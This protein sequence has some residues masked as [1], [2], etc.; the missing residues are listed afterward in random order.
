MAVK[1]SST[2]FKTLLNQF[3]PSVDVKMLKCLPNEEASAI[4][5]DPTT[6]Q[7][8]LS[9]LSWPQQLIGRVHYSWLTPV[10][11]NVSSI[12]R[13]SAIAALPEHQS[14]KLKTH[15]KISGPLP[16]L[17]NPIKQ[18]WAGLLFRQWAPE[19]TLPL[20][21]LPSSKLSPLLQ[22]KKEELVE[23]IDLL[24]M[25]DVADAVKHIVDKK[26]LTA[27]YTC[28]TVR[29]QQYLRVCM[30][31]KN[32]MTIPQLDF[33][34]WDGKANSFK[35]IVHQR[36]MLRLGKAICGQSRAFTWHLTHILDTGRGKVIAS[37]YQEVEIPGV[38]AILIQQIFSLFNFL[39]QKSD[40]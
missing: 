32:K 20:S 22:M 6:G 19:E 29:Q 34:K 15:L 13:P 11:N 12:L 5:E 28:L 30:H 23:F 40:V 7:D 26:R 33:D 3:H 14:S 21:Y 17:A 16:D 10:I 18:F 35:Q 27:I 38:T 4:L 9:L 37:Y 8:A 36:G 25:N 24:A 39:K 2:I 1:N 31:Q